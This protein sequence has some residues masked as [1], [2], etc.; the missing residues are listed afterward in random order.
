[1]ILKLFGDQQGGRR[2]HTHNVRAA[3]GR[4][5]G[6]ERGAGELVL[7]ALKLVLNLILQG[8]GACSEPLS[9]ALKLEEEPGP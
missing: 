5:E 3:G 4:G 9:R 6:A 2:G 7:E 1:M 8:E